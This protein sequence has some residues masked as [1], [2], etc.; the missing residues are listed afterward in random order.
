[1]MASAESPAALRPIAP[2]PI[3]WSP[4]LELG[5]ERIDAQHQRLVRLHND[6]VLGLSHGVP[7]DTATRII[8]ELRGYAALHFAEEEELIERCGYPLAVAHHHQHHGFATSLRNM[9]LHIHDTGFAAQIGVFMG[10][11]IEGHI[12]RSDADIA[13]YIHGAPREHG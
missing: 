4:R 10:N 6:L 5:I 1:M 11:W 9:A 7:L 13:R 8:G 2:K 12:A 3:I